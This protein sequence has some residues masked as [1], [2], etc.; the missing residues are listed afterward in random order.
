MI[1]ILYKQVVPQVKPLILDQLCV[2]N[3]SL[4]SLFYTLQ[5]S[6][7]GNIYDNHN[8]DKIDTK[9]IMMIMIITINVTFSELGKVFYMSVSR[10]VKK[11]D[12]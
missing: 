11:L 12:R 8:D 1:I 7:G 10:L 3:S 9:T 2:N 4:F 5:E 6:K